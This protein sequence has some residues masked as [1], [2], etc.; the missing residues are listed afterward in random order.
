MI[1]LEDQLK[2]GLKARRPEETEF[3]EEVVRLVDT[4]RLPRKLVDST[5]AW[6]LKR[7][8][9]YPFPAFERAL[10]LQADKLGVDL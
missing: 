2:T 4:G 10:R 3:I 5:F 7:R 6:A 9:T 8:Q 1:S